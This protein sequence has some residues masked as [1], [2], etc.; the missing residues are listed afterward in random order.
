MPRIGQALSSGLPSQVTLLFGLAHELGLAAALRQSG[1]P[2]NHRLVALSTVKLGVETVHLAVGEM[3][4]IG[5]RLLSTWP[6]WGALA[7]RCCMPGA[8]LPRIGPGPA[9]PR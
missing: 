4:C 7:P 2:E 3:A 5:V 9:W 8:A 6:P 1:V